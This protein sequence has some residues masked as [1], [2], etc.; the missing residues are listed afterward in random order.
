M[1]H[2]IAQTNK[3]RRWKSAA[4]FVG[5]LFGLTLALALTKPALLHELI[6]AWPDQDKT[7]TVSDPRLREALNSTL[8]NRGS[9]TRF[10][11]VQPHVPNISIHY[12]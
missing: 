4:F 3:S 2:W 6:L 9:D 10:A 11:V 1:A 12:L 7:T 5:R 8:R